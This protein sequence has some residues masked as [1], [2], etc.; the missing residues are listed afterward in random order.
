MKENSVLLDVFGA[1]L[2]SFA[3]IVTMFQVVNRFVTPL[4]AAI[5]IIVGLITAIVFL[6][7]DKENRRN[8]RIVSI[9]CNSLA[10]GSI[11]G[12]LFTLLEMSMSIIPSVIIAGI[13]ACIIFLF[14]YL[15]YQ[16]DSR[17]LPGILGFLIIAIGICLYWLFL[18]PILGDEYNLYAILFAVI[19]IIHYIIALIVVTSDKKTIID[20]MS[21][22]YFGVTLAILV[23]AGIFLLI[24][25][26][27]DLDI[28]IDVG[29][30]AS[31][32]SGKS[33]TVAPKV[34]RKVLEAVT[35]DSARV[36]QD[37]TADLVD[38]VSM[39]SNNASSQYVFHHQKHMIKDA[40]YIAYLGTILN[41]LSVQQIKE[42]N[43]LEKEYLN[44][45]Y[46][47]EEYKKKLDKYK[48]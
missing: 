19:S 25:S 11:F 3:I 14:Y 30:G 46:T 24:A 20:G 39:V 2:I 7:I 34:S 33:S 12:L 23:V 44:G 26:D 47:L 13:F 40:L 18:L 1:L 16:F 41:D 45:V 48:S 21:Y 42:L 27:G 9:C 8:M 22:G 36:A 15:F 37:I 10:I 28:D 4:Y 5:F 35:S 32:S 31:K 17:I 43:V 6:F 38:S 29:S